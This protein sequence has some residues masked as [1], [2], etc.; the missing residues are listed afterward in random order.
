MS[1]EMRPEEERDPIAE[2]E[3]DAAA[4]EAAE[5]GGP[6]PDDPGGDPAERPLV[7]S[8]EG[9]AEGFEVAEAELVDNAEHGD[10][11][12]FP[13]RDAGRPEEPTDTVYGEPDQEIHQDE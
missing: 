8:G 7:E 13:N 12:G 1:T 10:E 5:I 3:A 4:V 6:A 2:E 11:R 9:E